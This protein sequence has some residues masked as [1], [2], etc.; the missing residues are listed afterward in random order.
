VI[1]FGRTFVAFCIL[2]LATRVL[3]KSLKL[4]NGKQLLTMVALGATSL[5]QWV[6]FFKAI[7]ESTVS[8]AVVI[9]TSYPLFICFLEPWLNKERVKKTDILVAVLILV[10]VYIAAPGFSWSEES[11]RGAIFAV[12]SGFGHAANIVL[13]R[14]FASGTFPSLTISFYEHFFANLL[15]IPLLPFIL[16]NIQGLDFSAKNIGLIVLL[17]VGFSALT[18]YL[19]AQSLITLNARTVGF[20]ITLEPIYAILFASAL[21]NEVPSVYTL[22]GGAMIVGVIFARQLFIAWSLRE[23]KT[24]LARP[25]N[26]RLMRI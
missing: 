6:F 1:I 17:G 20:I 7:Q 8:L 11:N 15:L 9:F 24:T 23:P 26:D 19:V 2:Y 21:L 14:K 12:I 5:L 4:A 25:P 3:S 18:R 10:A 22:V 13:K 16:V